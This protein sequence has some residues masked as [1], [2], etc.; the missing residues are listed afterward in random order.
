MTDRPEHASMEAMAAPERTG[1]SVPVVRVPNKRTGRS[2]PVVRVPDKRTGRGTRQNRKE[3]LPRDRKPAP[4]ME[5]ADVWHGMILNPREWLIR[6]WNWK[7]A[8][9]A[10]VLRSVIFFSS[11]FKAGWRAAGAAMV[12]EFGYRALTSGF[13]GAMTQAFESAKPA[14]LATLSALLVIPLLSHGLELLVHWL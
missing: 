12:V 9:L 14:W 11:N 5:V 7:A 2:V 10:S 6:R 8:V 3:R 1:R 13:W 4:G